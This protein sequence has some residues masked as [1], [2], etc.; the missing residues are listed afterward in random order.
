V[1]VDIAVLVADDLVT[2]K[3]EEEEGDE[4]VGGNVCW[5]GVETGDVGQPTVTEEAEPACNDVEEEDECVEA[6][7][8]YDEARELDEVCADNPSEAESPTP[9]CAWAFCITLLLSSR[10]MRDSWSR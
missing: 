9:H 8:A 5:L 1:K 7:D 10:N 4:G 2:I 3:E 6:L